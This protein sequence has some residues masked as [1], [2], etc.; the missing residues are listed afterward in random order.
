MRM[1]F[2]FT[3]LSK[4]KRSSYIH[5]LFNVKPLELMMDSLLR[6]SNIKAENE[7]CIINKGKVKYRLDFAV[8]CRKGSINIECD[9]SRHHSQPAQKKKDD[10]RDRYMKKKGWN[11]I[12]F[13]DREITEK[14]EQCIRNVKKLLKRLGGLS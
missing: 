2:G 11:V 1:V 13:T 9:N 12:R 10:A 5:Q 6:K 8:F 4:L 14:P 3:S 7:Y